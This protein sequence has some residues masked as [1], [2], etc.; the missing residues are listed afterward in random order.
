MPKENS[1]SVNHAIPESP[2][3]FNEPIMQSLG[4]WVPWQ[5][6]LPHLWTAQPW[7]SSRVKYRSIRVVPMGNSR[8]CSNCIG[9]TL[10]NGTGWYWYVQVNPLPCSWENI[11]IY[12]V[13]TGIRYTLHYVTL[14][15]VTLHAC[16]K[17]FCWKVFA[18]FVSLVLPP[19]HALC[20]GSSFSKPSQ[21]WPNF[22]QD[23]LDVHSSWSGQYPIY[24]KLDIYHI[25]LYQQPWW[26]WLGT[27]IHTGS[28]LDNVK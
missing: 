26:Y 16:L 15:Y 4:P 14:P 1:P 24:K 19:G 21:V 27:Y 17:V 5:Q 10:V 22:Q 3:K 6:H 23:Y 18:M 9:S 13:Y 8:I 28:T 12:N 25:Q 2:I 20:R 7:T 11:Y